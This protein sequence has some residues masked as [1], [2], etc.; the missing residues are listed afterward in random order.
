MHFTVNT[1][2]SFQPTRDA[3]GNITG[4]S[5]ASGDYNADGNNNDYPNVG[6]YTMGTGRQALLTGAIFKSNFTQP[7]LGTEGNEKWG[8]FRNPG[9]AETDLNLSKDTKFTER[10]RL[11]L[12][13]EFYNVFNRV[14]LGGINANLTNANFGKSTSQLNPRNIQI[15]AK[16]MF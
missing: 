1:S 3:S 10:L 12:R 14:N 6:N 7:T 8:Q 2:A 13:F 16:I 4:L 5:A 9:F 11:Q 15:G